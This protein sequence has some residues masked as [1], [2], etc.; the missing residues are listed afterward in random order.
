MSKTLCHVLIS[1]PFYGNDYSNDN[2]R[3]TLNNGIVTTW[4]NVRHRLMT[5]INAWMTT[6]N[7]MSI[8]V[9]SMWVKF[10]LAVQ[11]CIHSM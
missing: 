8:L 4:F 6:A 3:H 10:V 5:Q 11:H 7:D 9:V 1:N 2:N